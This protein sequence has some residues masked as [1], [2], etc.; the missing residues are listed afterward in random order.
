MNAFVLCTQAGC[1]R[2]A[3]S[4][5]MLEALFRGICNHGTDWKK[6]SED[7][8]LAAKSPAQSRVKFRDL[9]EHSPS[10]SPGLIP[11]FRAAKKVAGA[12]VA[13]KK[14][15]KVA[16]TKKCCMAASTTGAKL[17][18]RPPWALAN[19]PSSCPHCGDPICVRDCIVC[20]RSSWCHYVCCL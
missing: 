7:P 10:M 6:I 14:D 9:L 19:W 16:A 13:S 5:V 3:Y 4:P 18:P 2:D 12:I 11:L 17:N 15:G 8:S 1:A 20:N